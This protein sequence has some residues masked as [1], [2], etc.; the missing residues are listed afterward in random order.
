MKNT[1][2]LKHL[3]IDA[4]LQENTEIET[5]K[6]LARRLSRVLRAKK[7]D[8]LALFNGEDGLFAAEILD[9]KAGQLRIDAC[10]KTLPENAFKA[11]LFIAMTKKDA[12]DRVYRQATEMGVNL[13]V[14]LVT[15]FTMVDKINM[16]RASTI[17]LEASEQCERLDIPKI[18]PIEKLEDA[19]ARMATEGQTI[20]WCAEHVGGSWLNSLHNNEHTHYVKSGDAILIGPEGGFSENER[21]S[22]AAQKHVHPVGLGAHILRVDTA[23]VAALSRYFEAVPIST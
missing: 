23:V 6:A 8:K 22:L 10:I 20:F 9:E 2:K 5:P 3:Y 11:V 16:D 14:P 1:K 12:M 7:G 13:I 18:A 15:D 17:L 21:A 4:P 19:V